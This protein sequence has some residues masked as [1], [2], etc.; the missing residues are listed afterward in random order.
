MSAEVAPDTEVRRAR[1]VVRRKRRHHR[2]SWWSRWKDRAKR[3][4]NSGTGFFV[5]LLLVV[6]IV[7]ALFLW[8]E[9]WR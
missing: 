5:L 2:R 4:L 7:V 3:W 6:A 9:R 1:K 8:A